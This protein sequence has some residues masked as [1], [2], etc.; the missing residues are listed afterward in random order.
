MSGGRMSRENK[1]TSRIPAEIIP[2]RRRSRY[3]NQKSSFKS[4]SR[5]LRFLCEKLVLNQ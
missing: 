2:R 5:Y 1:G 3:P 4:T